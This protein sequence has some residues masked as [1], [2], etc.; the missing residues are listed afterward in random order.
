MERGN[1]LLLAAKS[2]EDI[3]RKE[4]PSC[5]AK[6]AGMIFALIAK[7]RRKWEQPKAAAA[8]EEKKE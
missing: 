4:N 5:T 3:F 1:R 6:S 8:S 7:I 2:A